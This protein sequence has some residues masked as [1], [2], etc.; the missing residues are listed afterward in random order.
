MSLEY[1]KPSELNDITPE[2]RKK[3]VDKVTSF[4]KRVRYKFDIGKENPDPQKYNGKIIYPNLYTLDPCI[5]TV[6]DPNE[7]RDNKSKSKRIALIDSINEKGGAER[8]KKIRVRGAHRGVLT[9]NL[10]E[11]N[12]DFDIAMMLELH[13]KVK[14]G[15]FP[16]KNL[17]MV[18]ERVDEQAHAREQRLERTAKVK[19]LNAVQ[20]MS[21]N[22][23]VNFADAMLWDSTEEPEVLRNKIEELA[24]T[25]SVFF[26][27]LVS[28]KNIEYQAAIKQALTKGI[29]S[30]DPA[31]YKF[32]WSGNQQTITVLSPVGEK[33]E[34]EKFAEFL[35]TGGAKSDEIYKKIKG[36]IKN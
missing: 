5:I 9:L 26:N 12:E 28:G 18:V 27:D 32:I 30:F 19:A 16:N 7:K 24:E 29:V 13:P 1:N 10:E 6:I 11:G 21:D 35:Q 36:L 31:E 17:H 14:N 20:G 23:L 3:L 34:V 22:D 25:N 4:G 2:L 8:F 33:N 15:E